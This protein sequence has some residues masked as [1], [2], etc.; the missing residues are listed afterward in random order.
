MSVEFPML[1]PPPH[2][3]EWCTRKGAEALKAKI[4]AYWQEKGRPVQVWIEPRGFAV[5]LRGSHYVVRSDLVGGLPT[6]SP[7]QIERAA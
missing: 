6:A 2:V 7:Q 4:E 1:E 3:G 5:S